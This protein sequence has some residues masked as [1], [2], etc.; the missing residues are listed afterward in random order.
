MKRPTEIGESLASEVRNAG[1]SISAITVLACAWPALL[2]AT[3]CLLPFL[4]K[5]FLVDDPWFLTMSRQIVEHPLHPMDFNICWNTVESCTKAYD[6]TP[7]NSLMG[8]VLVPTVLGGAHEWVAHLTQLILVWIAILAMTSLI[9][10]LGWDKWHAV[11]GSLLLV[12]IPPFLPMASTAIPDILAT[13]VALVA[14]DRLAAWKIEQK[15]SQGA[16]GAIAL[17]LAGFARPHLALLLPLAAFFLLDSF[18]LKKTLGQIRQR[19][20]MWSPVFAG[21]GLLFAL[22]LLVREHD[23]ALAPPPV[24]AGPSNIPPNLLVYLAYFAFPLPLTAC[25][26]ANRLA[27]KSAGTILIASAL[28]VAPLFLS[29]SLW[30]GV[31]LAILGLLVLADLSFQAFNRRDQIGLFLLLWALIP[32]PIVYYTHLPMKYL[33]PCVPAVILICFRLLDGAP[34]KFARIGVMVLIFAGTGYSLLI[35]HSDAEFADFGRDAL[36]RLIEPHIAAGQRVWYPGQYWSY[37]YAPLAGAALTY[38][39]GPQPKPGDLIV[40]DVLAAGKLTPLE[41]F[42]HRTLVQTIVHRYRFGRTMGAG[43]GLYANGFGF[44][45]WGLGDSPDD[46]FELWRID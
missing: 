5:A 42:P 20:W 33:L 34:V 18:D 28:A 3:V 8:Y 15:W 25:W 19:P 39:D 22:I 10:R 27:G 23:L 6:L 36:Q 24:V 35:L 11:A 43:K 16:A 37:W 31:L 44:W 17:G 1:G 29:W 38:P 40:L 41:R 2:L 26:L 32:L 7:G 14:I 21:S 12:A 9:F 46:R 30:G 45:M 4:N 13:A